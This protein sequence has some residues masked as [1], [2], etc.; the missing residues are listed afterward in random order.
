[1]K[2]FKLHGMLL[3]A[4]SAAT[5]IEGDCTN[6]NWYDW[7]L[8]GHI[9]DNTSPEN[10]NRHYKYFKE[11]IAL[12]K[13]MGLE[14]ARIG[15]EWA[16]IEPEEGIFD[17][18]VLDHYKEELKLMN[19]YGIKPL[20]TLWHFSN[21]LWFEKKGGFLSGNAR[22]LFLEYVSKVISHLG[23]YIESWVTLNEPNVYGFNA[24]F[25]GTWP[26]GEKNM[27]R[28]IQLMNKFN[29]LHIESYN[30][31]HRSFPDAKVGTSLHV[32][33]YDPKDN[34]KKNQYMAKFVENLMQKGL[35][36]SMNTG[37]VALPFKGHKEGK[38]YDFIGLNYYS[39]S[40]IDGFN[41]LVKENTP[42]NDLEWE[43]YPEGLRRLCDEFY[44]KYR[45][46]IYITENGTCDTHDKFRSKFIYDHL[47]ELSKLDYVERYYHWCFID[48]W[49]WLE[50]ESAR[51]GLIHNDYYTQ[52]RTIKKSG[53]FYQEIIKENGVSEEMYERYVKDE[54]YNIF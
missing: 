14:V 21:P 9:K 44:I 46:P 39:R 7:Y 47:K 52:K 24:Y 53:K 20:V 11:D 33:I 22:S 18:E 4:A 43:I 29:E 34:S 26:P 12:M 37:K 5:Q 10:A 48:N 49:E 36:E 27:L 13:E 42:R 38:Y 28:Y 41:N 2:S 30:M 51:F 54:K 6:T 1:M 15:L 25:E 31:I 17:E 40:I 3:G 19:K 16:R 45:A 23:E 32:R 35:A 8:K 50:G